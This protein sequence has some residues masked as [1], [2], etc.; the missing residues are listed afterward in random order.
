MENPNQKSFPLELIFIQIIG[1]VAM[2]LF[3]SCHHVYSC[4]LSVFITFALMAVAGILQKVPVIDIINI[5]MMGVM[6][7]L[8]LVTYEVKTFADYCLWS[9]FESTVR[10]KIASENAEYLLNIQAKEM[11]FMIGKQVLSNTSWRQLQRTFW[12]IVFPVN[13]ST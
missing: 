8:L 1:S 7:F 2:P 9:H 5:I 13:V 10:A 11:R 3:F 6:V 12:G 4:L